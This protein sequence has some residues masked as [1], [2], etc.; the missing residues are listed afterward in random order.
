MIRS[1]FLLIYISLVSLHPAIEGVMWLFFIICIIIFFSCLYKYYNDET[2][3]YVKKNIKEEDQEVEDEIKKIEETFIKSLSEDNNKIV[4]LFIDAIVKNYRYLRL[5]QLYIEREKEFSD[6]DTFFVLVRKTRDKILKEGKPNHYDCK[7]LFNDEILKLYKKVSQQFEDLNLKTIPFIETSHN[8]DLSNHK[9]FFVRIENLVIPHFSHSLNKNIHF[10]IYPTVTIK[11]DKMGQVD[12]TEIQNNKLTIKTLEENNNHIAILSFDTIDFEIITNKIEEAKRFYNSYIEL[13]NYLIESE[14]GLTVNNKEESRKEIEINNILKSL[15][16]LIGLEKIKNDFYE[17]ANFIKIQQ[18]RKFK[19]LK[20][21]SVNYHC[22]FVGNPGT[23]KTSMAR[24]LAD[25]YKQMGLVK[26]G[27]FIETDRSGLV[28]EYMGQT[29]V[30][31]NKVIDD[32]IGGVLFIDEAYSL[33]SDNDDFG[34]EAISTLLK[35]MEDD[36]DKFIVI[37]AGYNNEM[38]KFIESNP[39][40]KSRFTRTFKFEDYSAD[41]LFEIFKKMVSDN[42]YILTKEAVG[43]IRKQIIEAVLNKDKNF[44]NARLIRNVFEKTLQNQATRLSKLHNLDNYQLQNIEVEDIPK[45]LI[46]PEA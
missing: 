39:G 46:K 21:S 22:I 24:L 43:K 44:G 26:T 45:I 14:W 11:Y 36:R 38:H 9:F 31:T 23:G 30:K 15:D 34:K 25:L 2:P 17:I 29:A 5:K 37:L 28:A 6:D 19:G 12:F 1:D 8:V 42:D 27:Q 33:I 41:E 16:N 7:N 20:T 35:R 40:L 4:N 18:I 32:A 3:N 13:Q 10:Y